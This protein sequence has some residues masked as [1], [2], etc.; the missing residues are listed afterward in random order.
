MNVD[1]IRARLTGG[2][3]PFALITS[4]GDKYPVPH[5]E[6]ILVTQRT[7]VVADEEGFTTL[8]EPLHITGIE[9]IRVRKNG[10]R[11]RDRKQ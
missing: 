2:F 11:K 4:S 1:H 8:L 3:R 5:P 6:F 10:R 9:D 7:V